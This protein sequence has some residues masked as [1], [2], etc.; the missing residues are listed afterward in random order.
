MAIYNKTKNNNAF[1]KISLLLLRDFIKYVPLMQTISR[2][3][4]LNLMNAP[5]TI[6]LSRNGP[7]FIHISSIYDQ[8]LHHIIVV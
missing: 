2:E 1:D 7:A 5:K 6:I 3:L 4:Q 8:V